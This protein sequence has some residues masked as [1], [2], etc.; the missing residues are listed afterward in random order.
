MELFIVLQKNVALTA[1][2]TGKWWAIY[3]SACKPASES[4]TWNVTNDQNV[5]QY[6]GEAA[7][8]ILIVWL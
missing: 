1:H 8:F 7:H 6:L 5:E 4:S 2:V 3:T